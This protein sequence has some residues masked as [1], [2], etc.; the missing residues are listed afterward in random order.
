MITKLFSR[1]QLRISITF[2]LITFRKT[3]NEFQVFFNGK[4]KEAYWEKSP[5]HEKKNVCT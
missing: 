4:H 1:A 5:E 2:R 3:E